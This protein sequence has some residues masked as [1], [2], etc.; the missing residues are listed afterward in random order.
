[1]LQASAAAISIVVGEQIERN[2]ACCGAPAQATEVDPTGD[3]W[4]RDHLLVFRLQLLIVRMIGTRKNSGRWTA[5]FRRY[6]PNA[7]TAI[8]SRLELLSATSTKYQW[9]AAR[10]YADS[11]SPGIP[12]G[13][14]TGTLRRF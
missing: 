5:V 4:V 14:A 1:M 13:D 7:S 6:L 9:T 11:N 10:S 3:Q 2:S 12:L 8:L